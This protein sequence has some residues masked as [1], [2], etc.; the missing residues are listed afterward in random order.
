MGQAVRDGFL[1]AYYK[2]LAKTGQPQT[3]SFYDTSQ[4]TDIIALYQEAINKGADIVIGPLTKENVQQMTRDGHF[5]VP[6]IALNYTDIWLGSLPN[7]LYQFGLSPL[8]ETKQVADKA[9]ETGH[10]RA[11]IIAPQTEW[12]QHTAKSFMTRWQSHG[13]IVTDTFYFSNPSNFMQD[14]ARLLHVNPTSEQRRQDFDVIFLLA[15]PE[16]ARQIVPL[17]KYYYVDNSIPIYSTSIVYSGTPSPEKDTDLNGVLFNDI[18]WVLHPTTDAQNNR[19]YA[20]GLDV[21]FISH[22]LQRFTLL[23]QFP[24]YMATGALSL[25]SQ[26]QFYRRLP[27]AQIHDGHP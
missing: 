6:T 24:A 25:N 5:S 10:S 2:H 20:V 14:I 19:L 11:L 13:G 9:W 4:K 1:N 8:D 7:N 17:L 18:P 15:P 22:E 16:N 21:Y 23:P 26:K 3:L 12:G 27:W